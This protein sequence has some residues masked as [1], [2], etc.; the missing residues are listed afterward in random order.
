MK[1]AVSRLKVIEMWRGC[2]MW[3]ETREEQ[4]FKHLRN[5]VEV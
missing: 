4:S 3:V 2:H 1:L 5:I